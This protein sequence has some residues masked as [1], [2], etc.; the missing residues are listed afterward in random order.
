MA[1]LA[2]CHTPV[3]PSDCRTFMHRIVTG[4]HS[5]DNSVVLNRPDIRVI[6]MCALR[7]GCAG[8]D[9]FYNETLTPPSFMAENSNAVCE[10]AWKMA[11]KA[12]P[13]L[14]VPNSKYAPSEARH[15]MTFTSTRVLL[16]PIFF[17]MGLVTIARAR[18]KLSAIVQKW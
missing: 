11:R 17:D 7:T 5:I 18:C 14:G 16:C 10:D 13:S 9:G 1:V 4:A 6:V 2:P 12:N 8:V 3:L 15:S